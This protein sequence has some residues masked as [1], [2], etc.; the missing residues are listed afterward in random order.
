MNIVFLDRTS[1]PASHD[2]PRPSFPHTFA[3]LVAGILRIAIKVRCF[4]AA[5]FRSGSHKPQKS[6]L[7]LV[8]AQGLL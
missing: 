7:S 1:I 3:K 2:I 6:F 4:F 5:F 8:F